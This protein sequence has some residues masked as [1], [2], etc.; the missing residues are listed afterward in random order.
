VCPLPLPW[1]PGQVMLLT[2]PPPAR[3]GLA[4]LQARLRQ[5]LVQWQHPEQQLAPEAVTAMQDSR[6]LKHLLPGR[7]TAWRQAFMGLVAGVQTGQC[8]AAYAVGAL[9]GQQQSRFTALFCAAAVQDQQGAYAIMSRTTR[10]FRNGLEAGGVRFSMPH[11]AAPATA[12]AAAAAATL[13]GLPAAAA[14]HSAAAAAGT[15]SAKDFSAGSL[16]VVHGARHVQGLYQALLQHSW[17]QGGQDVPLLLAPLPFPGASLSLLRIKVNCWAGLGWAGLGWAGL[18]WAGLGWAGLGWAG[19]GWAGLGCGCAVPQ[20]RLAA[21]GRALVH[22]S[23]RLVCMSAAVQVLPH[24]NSQQHQAAAGSSG[25]SKFAA[26]AS[27]P[28]AA[29][30][31]PRQ[32]HHAETSGQL[33]TPWVLQRLISSLIDIQGADMEINVDTEACSSVNLAAASLAA[34]GRAPAGGAAW[35]QHGRGLTAAEVAT[36]RTQPTQLQGR[37]SQKIVYCDQEEAY[38][39]RLASG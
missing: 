10:Q 31:A 14:S 12:A 8:P 27:A 17:C 39:V 24:V 28:A 4:G 5:A 6:Q 1:P 38:S 36:L 26:A 7:V 22:A 32:Q 15:G 23:A 13:A 25:Q 37:V 11:A 34:D 29:G 2:L 30:L 33:V 3:P 9:T 19:L 18:G 21:A 20:G 35:R 16:V